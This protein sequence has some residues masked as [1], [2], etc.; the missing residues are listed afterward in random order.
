MRFPRPPLARVLAA[1]VMVLGIGFVTVITAAIT[2]AFVARTRREERA[3]TDD[4]APLA[5][6]IRE[7]IERLERIEAEPTLVVGAAGGGEVPNDRQMDGMDMTDFLLGNADESGR[8]TI[9]CL[10]GVRLQAVKWR[11]WKA[12]LF[13][14]DDFY[15]TWAPLNMPHLYNLEW[16][17]R[18][19]HQ[20]NF[21]H[22]WVA[23]PMAAAAAAFLKTLAQEP[24]IKPGDSRPIHTA[25]ARRA[26]APR[27]TSRSDRSRSRT[28]TLVK[29]HEQ[30]P[31]PPHGIEH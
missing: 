13:H 16:D 9:L 22:G 23:H 12:N 3:A 21:P 15:S 30:L 31:G 14:Q 8:N 28:T 1:I 4:H 27:N 24:P 29:A 20:V 25:Q 17:P 10:Q 26:Y 7:I 2:G 19:E 11:Q 6:Q 5:D 18:E